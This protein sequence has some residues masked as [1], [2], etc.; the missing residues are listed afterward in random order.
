MPANWLEARQIASSARLVDRRD[1]RR[2]AS[3][4]RVAATRHECLVHLG[5][6]PGGPLHGL[7]HCVPHWKDLC[8]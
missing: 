3:L 4:G 6:E 2:V 1:R 7:D 5:L 8:C